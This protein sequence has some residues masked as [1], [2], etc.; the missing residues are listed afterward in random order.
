M[1]QEECLNKLCKKHVK[2][3]RKRADKRNKRLK[4]SLKEMPKKLEEVKDKLKNPNRLTKKQHEELIFKKDF[5][6]ALISG[7]KWNITKKKKEKIDKSVMNDCLSDYCN[8]T[9]KDTI[10]ESGKELSE[11]FIKKNNKS[12]K[13]IKFYRWMR[14]TKLNNKT[15]VLKDGFYEKLSTSDINKMK[16]MGAI[17]GCV[18][19]YDPVDLE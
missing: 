5:Y 3:Y 11:G 15:N 9:C 6:N 19:S 2:T 14:K 8:P 12:E 18:P 10:Y 13:R 7:P 16:K 17:S 1:S 4:K